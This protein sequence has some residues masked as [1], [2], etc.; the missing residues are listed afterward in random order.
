MTAA[1]RFDADAVRAAL[2][3]AVRA[4]LGVLDVLDR[5]DSTQAELLRRGRA[6]QD[7]SVLLA[8]AQTAGR[9]RR[10]RAWVSPPDSNLYLSMFRR[11][12]GGVRAQAG[13]SL[14]LGIAAAE[15]VRARGPTSGDAAAVRVKWPNDLVADGRKLGGLLVETTGEGDGVVAG[16]GLNLRMPDSARHD[17]DQAWIDLAGLGID[18]SRAALAAAVIEAWFDAFDQ[19]A[20]DGLAAFRAR[21]ERLDALRDAP[22]R[23]VGAH[24]ERQGIARGI[25]DSGA[26]Q[27]EI[28]GAV[29]T[30]FSGD[31]SLRRA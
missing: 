15:A 24:G 10:G 27:V 21:W 17:I 1:A 16:L 25:A 4:R 13:L 6:Q 18:V 2:A 23:I 14:A 8:D 31:V 9:G 11:V 5:V 3:P 20:R 30:V 19:F 12:S 28:G 29:E 7:A 26:L 22:V